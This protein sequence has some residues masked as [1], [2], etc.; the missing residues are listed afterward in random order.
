MWGQ[1]DGACWGPV[2]AAGELQCIKA[3]WETGVDT[4]HDQ[5]LD[6][7]Q[8]V[9]ATGWRSLRHVALHWGDSD[10]LIA[11]GNVKLE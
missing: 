11:D 10:L 1:G 5:S 4:C 6:A 2:V 3:V 7:L 8:H 9:R